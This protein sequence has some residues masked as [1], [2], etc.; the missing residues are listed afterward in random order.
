MSTSPADLRHALLQL[1]EN[2]RATLLADIVPPTR[3]SS[4]SSRRNYLFRS[5]SS[6]ASSSSQ[7]ASTPSTSVHM[8]LGSL[9]GKAIF[10]VGTLE[11]YLVEWIIIQQKLSS[12]ARRFPHDD[13]TS[14][15]DI[16]QIYSETLELTRFVITF[17]FSHLDHD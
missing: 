12:Y 7:T 2:E 1:S 17:K 5:L 15:S 13:S 11:L 16:E 8:G 6:L 4:T 9:S 3:T 10:A 14:L